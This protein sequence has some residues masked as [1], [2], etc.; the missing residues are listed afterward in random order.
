MTEATNNGRI[1]G[2][3]ER[4]RTGILYPLL[5]IAAVMV[6]LFSVIGIATMMGL[7]PAASSE[8]DT[9]SAA[10]PVQT[11]PAQP[12]AP[13]SQSAPAQRGTSRHATQR[14]GAVADAR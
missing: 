11:A 8:S 3:G 2:H 14:R 9:T 5:L 4:K 10:E 7:I 13:Q 12:A 6:I 1:A